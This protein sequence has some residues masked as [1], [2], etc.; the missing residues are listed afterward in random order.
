[1][2]GLLGLHVRTVRGCVRD[3]R[4]K[5][6]RVGRQRR[7]TREDLEAFTG[8]HAVR[9][10]AAVTAQVPPSSSGQASCSVGLR[11]GGGPPQREGRPSRPFAARPAIRAVAYSS[12]ITFRER[13]HAQ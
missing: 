2:A 13:G 12:R 5:A 8:N 10:G 1:M 4:L 7:I 9:D 6:T 11:D 3:G